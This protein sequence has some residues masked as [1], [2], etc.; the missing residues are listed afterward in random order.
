MAF[1]HTWYNKLTN[2]VKIKGLRTVP[3]ETQE[4]TGK[5]SEVTPPQEIAITI[6]EVAV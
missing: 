1:G 5:K 4:S 3:R 6:K 2:I